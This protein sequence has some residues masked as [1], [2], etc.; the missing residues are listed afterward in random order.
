MSHTTLAPDRGGARRRHAV[1]LVSRIA[2]G[3]GVLVVMGLLIWQALLA[4]GNPDPMAGWRPTASLSPK[5]TMGHFLWILVA[6]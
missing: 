4:A 1:H 3:G 6:C 5:V 2:M